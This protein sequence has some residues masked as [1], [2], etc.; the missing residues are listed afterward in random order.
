[1]LNILPKI[2]SSKFLLLTFFLKGLGFIYLERN[3]I[4]ELSYIININIWNTYEICVQQEMGICLK[5]ERE[6]RR[7]IYIL[8]NNFCT[9]DREK[10]DVFYYL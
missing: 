8:Y 6:K 2:Q 3:I 1:M 9:G 10:Q 4:I 5:N 7:L